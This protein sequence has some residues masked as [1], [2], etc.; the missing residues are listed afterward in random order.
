MLS[1]MKLEGRIFTTKTDLRLQN[2]FHYHLKKIEIERLFK[3]VRVKTTDAVFISL[4]IRSIKS[5]P[6]SPKAFAIA[7]TMQGL[8]DI[9]PTFRLHTRQSN[10]SSG[11]HHGRGSKHQK[12]RNTFC[13]R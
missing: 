4:R 13:G 10:R 5:K 12:R 2:R 11:L 1:M 7:I 3:N 8:Q 6:P 9:A